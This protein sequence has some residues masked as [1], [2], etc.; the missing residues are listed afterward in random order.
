MIDV[1]QVDTMV[2]FNCCDTVAYDLFKES[3]IERR[4][5]RP[6]VADYISGIIKVRDGWVQI[7]GNRPKAIEEMKHKLGI[8]E[9]TLDL[10]KENLAHMTRKEA[11]EWL[12]ASTFPQLPYTR[13][14]NALLETLRG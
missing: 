4:K 14:M 6:R 8:E 1:N 12:V 2:S 3:P 7:A 9:I 10:I 5:R 11:F 13:L